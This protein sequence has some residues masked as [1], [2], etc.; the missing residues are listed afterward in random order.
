MTTQVKVTACCDANTTKVEVGIYE[1]GQP[2]DKTILQ[3]GESAEFTVYDDRKVLVEEVA[4]T[5]EEIAES[6]DE[7]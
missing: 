2:V 5:P 6:T 1:G 3:D 4:K 7:T